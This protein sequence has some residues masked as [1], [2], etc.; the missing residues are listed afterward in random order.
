TDG[1]NTNFNQTW[2]RDGTNTPIWNRRNLKT[3]GFMVM[4]SKVGAKPG[5]EVCITNPKFHH[6]A[7]S[8]LIDGRILVQCTHPKLGWGYF[9]MTPKPGGKNV[10]QR[11]DTAGLAKKG[12]LDR[13]SISPSEDKVCFEHQIGHRHNPIGRT[14][15]VADF[16]AKKLAFTNVKAFANPERKKRWYAYPRW[17]KGE[18]A[19][20][21]HATPELHLHTL[22][23]GVTTKVSTDPRAE[24]RYPHGEGMPK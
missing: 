24:Y 17:T 20:V 7:Y 5:Q 10:Y 19:I 14:L 6:W 21:F 12:L 23:S 1:K 3:G 2:T 16:S 18:R 9:L 22:K 11:I 15:F 4:K 8:C 13:I